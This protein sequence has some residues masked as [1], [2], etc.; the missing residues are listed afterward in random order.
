MKTVKLSYVE[1]PKND[2]F[3]R[4][5]FVIDGETNVGQNAYINEPEEYELPVGYTMGHFKWGQP[6]I[7][8]PKGMCCDIEAYG[9][10]PRI[11][12]AYDVVLLRK[13]GDKGK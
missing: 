7:V 6:A 2:P 10:T 12:S 8:D 9:K 3:T 1:T 4:N 11:I 5:T 13:K